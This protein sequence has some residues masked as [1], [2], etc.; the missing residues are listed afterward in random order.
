MPPMPVPPLV[1][2]DQFGPFD[3]RVW[4]NTA[5]QGPLPRA[6]VVAAERA[7]ALKAAPHRIDDD[8]FNQVPERLRGFLAE[9]VGGA[10]EEI[11]LGNS[12]SHGLHLIANGLD[13]R[14]GDEVLVVAGDYPATVLPW[15]RLRDQGVRVR[16][17]QSGAGPPSA[18]EL[19]AALT[20]A[21]RVFALTWVDSFTGHAADL[22]ALGAVCRSA[23]VLLVAN[24]SQAIGA[25]P[26]DVG[27]SPVDA[28]VSCG[29]KWLCGPYGTGFC[30]LHPD[31]LSRLRP[32]QSY[33]LAMQA[34]R[35]LEHMRD[36][37]VR[38]DL[39]VRALDVFCPADFG[40]V[41]PWTAAVRL[42]LDTG[43][44]TIADYDQQL[45]DQLLAGLDDGAYRLVSPP[46][47]PTRSTLVVLERRDG[48]TRQTHQ[49][50]HDAGIDAAFREGNLRLSLHL[51]NTAE[52]VS[53]ALQALHDTTA[54]RS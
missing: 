3:G 25:R 5:H 42:V 17:L 14:P 24:A 1:A 43:V 12:T 16:S 26:I 23:G 21:T 2:A 45:V 48:T 33:W 36:W 32:Q 54:S 52:D 27:R 4:L 38:D 53:R 29:Y 19:A 49:Q 40:D 47:G 39:G 50:L 22:D 15:L 51:F 18:E 30:W 37:T 35:G 9:L 28:V 13:W 46:A 44:T 20:P 11:V 34:G 41:L 31:L 8:H 7:A 10:S 6:G